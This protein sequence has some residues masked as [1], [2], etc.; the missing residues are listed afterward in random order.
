MSK[1]GR[2][3]DRSSRWIEKLRGR[4]VVFFSPLQIDSYIESIANCDGNVVEQLN[5]NRRKKTN[6]ERSTNIPVQNETELVRYS[7][8]QRINHHPPSSIL[9]LHFF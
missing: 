9:F 4:R 7:E 8:S 6:V 2:D 3:D 5:F 1:R